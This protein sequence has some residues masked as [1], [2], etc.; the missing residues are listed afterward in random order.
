MKPFPL[1]AGNRLIRNFRYETLYLS[2]LEQLCT[3][4]QLRNPFL[5]LEKWIYTKPQLRNHFL[6]SLRNSLIQN[7]TYTKLKKGFEFVTNLETLFQFRMTPFFFQCRNSR[8]RF[9]TLKI[10]G[11]TRLYKRNRMVNC[12]IF[13]KSMLMKPR[14]LT[15]ISWSTVARSTFF[16]L[17]NQFIIASC[18][19]PVSYST[20]F[21]L[22]KQCKIRRVIYR[23]L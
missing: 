19:R 1:N 2:L 18:I 4:P 6:C 11:N 10:V 13:A 7:L 15:S 5:M 21:T 20:I 8:F 16:F 23:D 9:F 22:K 3:K 14:L 17:R 12:K